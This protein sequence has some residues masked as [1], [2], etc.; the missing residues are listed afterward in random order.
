MELT[1]SDALRAYARMMNTLDVSHIEPLLS[2]NFHYASQWV[3]DEIMSKQ[4]FIDYIGPKLESIEKSGGRAYA[5]MAELKTYSGGPCVV[6]AQG[7][8]DNLLAT[9][10][11]EVEYGKIK[12]LDMCQ[13]PPPS[14]AERSGEY[15]GE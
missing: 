6:M 14:A 3:F 8:K 5:E 2:E 1:K 15:P 10:L 4:A 7:S 13:I 11:V 12:R 9:V